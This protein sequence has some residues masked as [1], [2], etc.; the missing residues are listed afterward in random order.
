MQNIIEGKLDSQNDKLDAQNAKL[1][2]QRLAEERRQFVAQMLVNVAN[3]AYNEQ[4]KQPCE[5]D[6]RVD[7]LAEINTWIYDASGQNFL[8]LTGDPG[9]GK[10]A[11]TA[12]VARSC[13]DAGV[14]WAQFFIN[15]NNAETTDPKSYFTS[16][17]RQFADH[18][19]D[20]D[21][22]LAIHD[23]LKK[24]PSI[25]DDISGDQ[26][27]EL[28]VNVIDVASQANPDMPVVVVIDG[29]DETDRSRSRLE[30]TAE[31]F[32]KLFAS[33]AGRNAK[34]FISSRTDDDIRRPF[35]KMFDDKHV[36]HIHLDTSATSS[37]QDV[38][39]FLVK[40]IANIVEKTILIGRNGPGTNEWNCCAIGR[41]ASSFGQ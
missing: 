16:I 23:A 8:W 31:I 18:S 14:L 10:S 30:V 29:L 33:L 38:S 13:K 27:S 3:T 35:S 17:A 15:R 32:S 21:V 2:A 26:A 11:I 37:I 25:I 4:G 36:K 34:V 1:E 9:S 40:R 5:V 22:V 41:Q 20:S 39:V 19:P 6:T 7:I 12:S 24:Q 28:F